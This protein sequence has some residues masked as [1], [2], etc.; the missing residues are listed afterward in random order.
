MF[1]GKIDSNDTTAIPERVFAL[2]KIVEKDSISED[3]LREKME[4]KYL[5]NKTKYFSYYKNAAEELGLITVSDKIVS[6]A[7]D[8]KVIKSPD[9]MRSYINSKLE[10]LNDGHFYALTNAYFEIGKEIF[11]K[12]KNIANLG[13][14]FSEMT[15]KPIDAYAMRAWRFWAS[16]LGFGY[17]QD[18]F[19]IPNANVFLWDV[20]WNSGLKKGTMYSI[21]DFIKLITPMASIVISN[22]LDKKFNYGVSSGLR[23]L[24]D[25]K[26][27]KIDHILDQ[28][29]TWTLDTLKTYSSDETV[30]HITIL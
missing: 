16:Y 2:C 25:S 11:K 28:K 13:P 24:H 21:S 22:P 19:L 29:D 8:E 10:L 18:M 1:S 9:N 6:L 20:I 12:E 27:I 26:K 7:V 5:E 4:P 17:L 23:A 30:T 15:G 3:E 14:M